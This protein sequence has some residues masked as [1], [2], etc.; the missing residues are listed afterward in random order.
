MKKNFTLIELLVVIAIIGILASLLLPALGKARKKSQQA[1]CASQQKQIGTAIFMYVEDNDYYM[2]TVNH[3]TASTRLG[4]KIFIAPYLNLKTNKLG[5]A[6]FRCP[7]SEIVA[8]WENQSA[9]TSYNSNFGDTRFYDPNGSVSNH[10]KHKP[11]EL[12]EIEDTVETV[13]TVDSID[14]NDWAEVAKSLPSSNAVGYRHNNGLNT[15]WVDGHVTWKSTVYMSAGRY[16]EQ[17]YY[18][19]M[20][21]P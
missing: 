3:P 13:V 11:K 9:G 19:I 16:G 21:K 10:R 17:N 5:G 1:V 7:S 2:P 14:G 15:L 12:N 18:Y 6:P 8:D 20:D 4:W